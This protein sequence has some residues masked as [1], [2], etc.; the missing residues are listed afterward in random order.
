[1]ERTAGDANDMVEEDSELLQFATDTIT[2]ADKLAE[3]LGI[4]T[5]SVLER[6][7]LTFPGLHTR[8]RRS[9]QTAW[10]IA[11]RECKDSVPAEFKK[12]GKDLKGGYAKYVKENL[13]EARKAEYQLVA[14]KENVDKDPKIDTVVKSIKKSLKNLEKAV[15]NPG[16]TQVK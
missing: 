6:A 2:M 11:L 15:N 3:R 14:E 4:S 1:M 7:G 13:Y 12:G 10:T 9:Q 5:T 16:K 8:I